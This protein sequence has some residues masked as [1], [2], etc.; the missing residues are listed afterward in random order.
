MVK[1]AENHLIVEDGED[2][3]DGNEESKIHKNK[4]KNQKPKH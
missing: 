1:E 4:C 2:S 3:E